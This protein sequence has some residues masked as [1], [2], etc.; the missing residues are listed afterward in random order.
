M[1]QLCFLFSILL[2]IVFQQVDSCTVTKN[3]KFYLSLSVDELY[4]QATKGNR[5][6]ECYIAEAK[7]GF[8]DLYVKSAI[9]GASGDKGWP[10][11]KSNRGTGCVKAPDYPKKIRRCFFLDSN[12]VLTE[13]ERSPFCTEMGKTNA[14]AQLKHAIRNKACGIPTTVSSEPCEEGS[15]GCICADSCTKPSPGGGWSISSIRLDRVRRC[16]NKFLFCNSVV[17]FGEYKVFDRSHNKRQ[18]K[19]L[20][21]SQV[22]VPTRSSTKNVVLAIAG[23]QTQ[24]L[25]L[26]NG[27]SSGLTGQYNT[28]AASFGRK[29][30]SV[31]TS[32]ASSSL[33]NTILKS[34][35]FPKENTFVGLVFDA[36]FNFEFRGKR[37]D[38]I[39]DAYYQYIL[40]RLTSDVSS[41]ETIYI[42]GHSRGGC[43]AMRLAARLTKSFP[44]K[45]IIIHN[46]DG[47]C[48]ARKAIAPWT[49]SEFGVQKDFISNPLKKKYFVAKTDI[50]RQLPIKGCLAVRSF[51][52]GSDVLAKIIGIKIN[53]KAIRGFGHHR[54]SE[55]SNSLLTE[56]KFEW[57]SQSFHTQ[58]HNSIDNF[59]HSTAE[60]HL[61]KAFSDLPCNCG[62]K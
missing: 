38:G 41:I 15:V 56:A 19:K 61:V 27:Q 25:V 14:V 24:K 45:R 30:G 7:S 17:T 2:V 40:N 57:Y 36:R 58:S 9:Q 44:T 21:L 13:E 55:S 20:F 26:P 22:N 32:V 50:E 46:Y 59:Y 49:K 48:T 11:T 42:A 1:I 16:R 43:L 52:S 54:F 29:T 62:A 12:Y 37:K 53:P 60:E 23:Q 6:G 35:Y 10:K 51:L 18:Q 39:V 34:G 4:D 5:V 31:S 47:V 8:C 33:V 28:Y 3:S